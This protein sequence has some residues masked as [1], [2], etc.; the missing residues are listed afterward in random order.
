MMIRKF[1]FW[2]HLLCGVTAGVVILMMS[3]TGVLLTYERQMVAWADRSAL[4]PV[5]V[6][7]QRLPLDQ[8]INSV[9]EHEPEAWPFPVTVY[10][11]AEQPLSVAL[12]RGRVL[13]L[14][15]YTGAVL[16]EGAKG[17]RAFFSLVLQWHRWFNVTGDGRDT[18]RA[19][20]G[21]S[22]LM[23]LFLVLSGMY[24][25]LPRTWKWVMFRV[26]LTFNPENNS[27]KA[28]DFNW[29]HVF[30]I[31]SSIPLAIVIATATVFSY[32]W[33]SNGVYRVFG[34]QPPA[35][36]GPPG[37]PEQTGN[38]NGQSVALTAGQ[39]QPAVNTLPVEQLFRSAAAKLEGWN[40]VTIR[41]SE[42]ASEPVVF[43]IDR[44]DGGQPHKQASLIL[45][46][47]TS[48]LVRFESF[49]D[50]SPGRQ[51]RSLIRRLHT[52]EALGIT[53]QTIAG[54]VSFAGIILV[55]T[56]LALAYRRLLQPLFR[57]RRDN[58]LA[59]PPDM[60]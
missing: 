36:G 23:F 7:A 47:R 19:I 30:G 51:A 56:G 31:W 22:N 52:G 11:D 59:Y 38:R 20:T 50:Q 55:W 60:Y 1:I 37:A 33:A 44:G 40:T 29:H 32:P 24:L 48:E 9:R 4:P 45:N 34:E 16:G 57:K 14:D 21:A 6:Q 3:V 25:W 53:G 43:S 28:R 2:C 13:Y 12:G 27:S 5:S 10:A 8:I 54:L 18:A 41:V 26:R 42:K 35:R 15:P 58:V 49:A 46:A 39:S 17:I